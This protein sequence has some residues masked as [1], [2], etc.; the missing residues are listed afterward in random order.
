MCVTFFSLC[1]DRLFFLFNREESADRE[2]DGLGYWKDDAN[3]LAGRDL[4]KGGTWFGVNVKTGNLAFLTNLTDPAIN[5]LPNSLSKLSRGYVI[6]SFIQSDFYQ[7]SNSQEYPNKTE[8][9]STRIKKFIDSILTNSDKYFPF[10]LIIGNLKTMSFFSVD[11]V[12]K[13]AREL[14]GS[15]L[16]GIANNWFGHTNRNRVQFGLKELAEK[17]YKSTEE[18]LKFMQNDTKFN[19][20]EEVN[21]YGIFIPMRHDQKEEEKGACISTTCLVQEGD[22]QF[23]F[24]ELQYLHHRRNIRRFMLQRK[25]KYKLAAYVKYLLLLTREKVAMFTVHRRE[26]QFKL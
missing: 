11:I 12:S 13:T 20:V 10:N 23:R 9:N 1:P 18:F 22:G 17:Q 2:T 5:Y 25:Y 7:K 8:N 24:V 6:K 15:T 4:E 16:H 14:D 3:I 26:F 21:Q 19:G